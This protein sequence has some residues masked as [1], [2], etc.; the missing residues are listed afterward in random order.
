MKTLYLV[1]LFWIESPG[2]TASLAIAEEVLTSLDY[3]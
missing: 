2:I 1:N 3:S